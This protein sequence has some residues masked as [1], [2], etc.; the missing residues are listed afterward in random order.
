MSGRK[1]EVTK[2]PAARVSVAPSNAIAPVNEPAEAG[3]GVSVSVSRTVMRMSPA[4]ASA[5]TSRSVPRT[6]VR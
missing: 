6:S 5:R 2:L 4:S 1:P 3:A